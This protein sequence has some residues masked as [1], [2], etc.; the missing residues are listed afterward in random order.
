[1]YQWKHRTYLNARY[2]D[3]L[4]REEDLKNIQEFLLR[5]KEKNA[6]KE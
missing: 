5:S 4:L 6:E 2:I 1:L 3:Y